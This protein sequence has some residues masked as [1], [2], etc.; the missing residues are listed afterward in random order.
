MHCPLAVKEP[1][2]RTQ[3]EH[4]FVPD[5]GMNVEAP[6]AIETQAYEVLRLD[7]VSRQRYRYHEWCVIEWEEQLPTVRMVVGMP[8]Q[9]ARRRCRITFDGGV[10]IRAVAEDVV[11]THRVVA[12]VEN[13]APP[14]A[15]EYSLGGAALVSGIRIHGSPATGIS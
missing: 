9:D 1:L 5:V 13:I 3:G 4:T 2:R 11:A 14:F 10:R 7:V 8:Q 15:V 12:A 6:A